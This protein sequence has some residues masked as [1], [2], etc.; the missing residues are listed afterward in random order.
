MPLPPIGPWMVLLV[1]L[2]LPLCASGQSPARPTWQISIHG[3]PEPLVQAV[4]GALQRAIQGRQE[5]ATVGPALTGDPARPD[6]AALASEATRGLLLVEVS[7]RPVEV[8]VALYSPGVPRPTVIIVAPPEGARAATIAQA[9]QLKV[10]FLLEAPPPVPPP[11]KPQ[12]RRPLPPALPED[13][14]VDLQDPGAPLPPPRPATTVPPPPVPFVGATREEAQ[15]EITGPPPQL[16]PDPRTGPTEPEGR[17]IAGWALRLGTE[18]RG[19]SR[20]TGLGPAMGLTLFLKAWRISGA[21]SRQTDEADVAAWQPRVE[22]GRALLH[23]PDAGLALQLGAVVSVAESPSGRSLD[24]RVRTGAT[25]AALG[26]L[27][28]SDDLDAV[29][30]ARLSAYGVRL[31]LTSETGNTPTRDRAEA[32]L[33]LYLRWRLTDG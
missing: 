33:G 29:L 31:E 21:I 13:R 26:V 24:R 22:I 30:E 32:A 25:G 27:R 1:C 15:L 7:P 11:P 12:R 5:T 19:D 17:Q 14:L 8:K 10:E 6:A 28:L 18:A 9:V 16:V 3:Q 2:T 23:G 20:S 4:R